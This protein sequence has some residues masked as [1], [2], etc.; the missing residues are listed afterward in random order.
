MQSLPSKTFPHCLVCLGVPIAALAQHSVCAAEQP[1]RLAQESVPEEYSQQTDE[2][3]WEVPILHDLG[4]LAT[5]RLSEAVIWPD[6]FAETDL[7][8]VGARYEEAFTKPPLW[9]SSQEAFEW[10]GDAWYLNLVGH[11]LLGSELYMRA[12]TCRHSWAM[13]WL[14]AAT[15]STAWE[16]G[17][18]AS[19]VRPSAQDLV[20]TPLVG[21]G[22]GELR[23]Q[24]F[25][26]ASRLRPGFW[27]GFA[28]AV[29]DPL[30]ELERYAKTSC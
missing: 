7:S 22:L 9:D 25:R 17:F 3:N 4:L 28:L 8:V 2:P 30:G 26:A 23:Y 11:G 19:G 14:F 24:G 13:S 6:P 20:Y 21:L 1:A 27:R 16:Y 10:D 5:L 15:F 12:R 18:E 29:V